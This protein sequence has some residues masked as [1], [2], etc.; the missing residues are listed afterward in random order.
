MVG[1]E[2]ERMEGREQKE[3]TNQADVLIV[4][5]PKA[6]LSLERGSLTSLIA[7]T[8]YWPL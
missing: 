5:L 8:R 4:F 1:G 6:A 7:G 2:G 3:R